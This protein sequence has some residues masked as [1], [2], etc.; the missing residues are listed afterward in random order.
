M[1]RTA[2]LLCLPRLFGL[3][4]LNILQQRSLLFPLLSLQLFLGFLG[5]FSGFL[6]LTTQAEQGI[7][8]RRCAQ[9]PVDIGQAFIQ[10]PLL[11][12]LL[13]NVSVVGG[14]ALQSFQGS[15]VIGL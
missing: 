15:R 11:Q 7:V 4:A 14:D 2:R 12:A 8:F 9:T 1:L 3:A 13:R 6:N 5:P 10:S